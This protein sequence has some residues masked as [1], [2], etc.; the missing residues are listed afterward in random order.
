M[1]K[2]IKVTSLIG[3]ILQ[4]FLALIFLVYLI[5]MMTGGLSPDLTT[6]VNGEVT[7]QDE[8]ISKLTFTILF[9]VLFVVAI[10]ADILGI[11]GLKKMK[12]SLKSSGVLYIIGA[13]VSFNMITF[14]AWLICGILLIQQNKKQVSQ[15]TQDMKYES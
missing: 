5:L 15:E 4:S 8:A 13:V 11:I 2:T 14:I 1:N 12:T 3:I 10:I 7:V 6:T 9:S